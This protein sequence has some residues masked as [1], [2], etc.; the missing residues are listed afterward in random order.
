MAD[1]SATPQHWWNKHDII[2]AGVAGS[3]QSI[4]RWVNDPVIRF[5]PGIRQGPCKNSPTVW[6]PLEVL[7]WKEKNIVPRKP[8]KRG[9][10][11]A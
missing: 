11:A 2:R 8:S 1:E 6:D 4:W 9:S 10:G 5:P 3:R 7:T